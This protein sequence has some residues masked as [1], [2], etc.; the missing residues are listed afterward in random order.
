MDVLTP[1]MG[2]SMKAMKKSGAAILALAVLM[3]G[4]GPKAWAKST[5]QARP[6]KFG[7]EPKPPGN[8]D[9]EREEREQRERDRAREEQSRRDQEQARE[10]ERQERQER[11]QAER[12][13]HR[14]QEEERQRQREEQARRDQE[15]QERERDRQREQEQARERERQ[16]RQ[17]REQAERDRHRQQEEERQRQAEERE[18]QRDEQAREREREQAERDRH[19]QQEE[20]R[21]RQRDEQARREREE[22]E[23]DRWE[24]DHEREE[25]ERAERERWERE[26]RERQEQDN[27][28]WPEPI[29]DDPVIVEPDP[30]PIPEPEPIVD[31]LFCAEEF[32]P[33]CAVFSFWWA[34]P[35]KE[36]TYLLPVQ[37]LEHDARYLKLMSVNADGKRGRTGTVGISSLKVLMDTGHVVDILETA[38]IQFPHRIAKNGQ[39]FLQSEGELLDIKLPDWLPGSEVKGISIKADSWIAPNTP[40]HLQVWFGLTE[41]E[42]QEGTLP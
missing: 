2:D 3:T 22:R 11:E 4:P 15:N 32:G 24:R 7:E 38:K 33:N 41:T 29:P 27:E 16:E 14:Q 40:A 13:R 19:R 8:D 31:E 20:E 37:L 9:R 25:R 26:E 5:P 1:S 21:Q 10:R 23:R 39:L 17:E 35:H 18:R 6:P 28:P 12:D 42:F 34:K 30:E 36:I